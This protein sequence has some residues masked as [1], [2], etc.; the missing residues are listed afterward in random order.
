MSKRNLVILVVLVL[1]VLGLGFLQ[2]KAS[3]S[4]AYSV[5]YLT[6]KEVYVGRLTT[7][8]DLQLKDGYILNTVQDAE[9]PKKT[10]FQLTPMNEALWAPQGGIHLIKDNVVF[11]SALSD[12]SSIAKTLTEKAK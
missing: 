2:Y 5:V 4:N 7:F 10:N 1:I 8:P 3:R 6:T 12:T 11:Y 9:D